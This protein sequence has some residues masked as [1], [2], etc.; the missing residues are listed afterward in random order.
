MATM[1]NLYAHPSLTTS[2]ELIW[3]LQDRLG[4]RAVVE[5][6]HVRLLGNPQWQGRPA[7][8]AVI[9]APLVLVT[10]GGA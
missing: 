6:R 3:A 9:T 1:T 10:G 5:G 4:L 7:P 2:P 8:P